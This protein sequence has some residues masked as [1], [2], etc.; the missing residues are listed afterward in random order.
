MYQYDVCTCMYMYTQSCVLNELYPIQRQNL[1]IEWIQ[2]SITASTNLPRTCSQPLCCSHHWWAPAGGDN[3]FLTGEVN[4]VQVQISASCF[5]HKLTTACT[6]TQ[7]CYAKCKNNKNYVRRS[8][9]HRHMA[10][11]K[12][13]MQ[14]HVYVV[15]YHVP[16]PSPVQPI[17]IQNRC[18]KSSNNFSWQWMKLWC[19]CHT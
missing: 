12:L 14:V 15:R 2:A 13:Y 18:I 4:P 17:I 16:G 10:L 11:V 8:L 9:V 6:L 7:P 3:C 1:R 19:V 5:L